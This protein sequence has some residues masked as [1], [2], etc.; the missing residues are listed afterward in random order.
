MKL[1]MCYLV[2][3]VSLEGSSE[4]QE[5]KAQRLSLSC[6]HMTNDEGWAKSTI[7]PVLG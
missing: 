4:G 5:D 1:F 7:D 3:C 6:S 2:P